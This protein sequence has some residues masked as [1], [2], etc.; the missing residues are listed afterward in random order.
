MRGERGLRRGESEWG[1]SADRREDMVR[2]A[3]WARPV[4]SVYG[5]HEKAK[6]HGFPSPGPRDAESSQNMCVLATAGPSGPLATPVRY[7]HLDFAVLFTAAARSPKR[8]SPRD[9]LDW[10]SRGRRRELALD[11]VCGIGPNKPTGTVSLRWTD[12]HVDI[13]T[14]DA[15]ADRTCP[16]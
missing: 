1:I 5:M 2:R 11:Y 8:P 6:R 10:F 9:R 14:L 16:A 3:T 15:S 12:I 7:F 13:T 4:A